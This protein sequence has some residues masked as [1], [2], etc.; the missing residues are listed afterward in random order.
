MLINRDSS[1]MSSYF[2]SEVPPFQSSQYDTVIDDHKP[3]SFT[4]FKRNVS[5]NWDRKNCCSDRSSEEIV[6]VSELTK[7]YSIFTIFNIST[8]WYSIK[9][10]WYSTDTLFYLHFFY[11]WLCMFIEGYQYIVNYNWLNFLW[12]NVVA[13]NTSSL[14]YQIET[15]ATAKLFIDKEARYRYTLS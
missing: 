8:K 7:W 10:N 1:S 2:W 13:I 3:G 15:D 9:L 14:H 5:E 4:W 12:R 6:W 11:K